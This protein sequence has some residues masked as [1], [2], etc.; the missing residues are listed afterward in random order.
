MADRAGLTPAARRGLSLAALGLA[1]ALALFFGIRFATAPRPP[2]P[3]PLPATAEA[4]APEQPPVA[5]AEAP[6]A[7]AGPAR[8]APPLA[9]PA[10]ETAAPEGS[11][12]DIAGSGS[13]TGA[14]EPDTDQASAGTEVGDIAAPPQDAG[15]EAAPPPVAEAAPDAPL[16]AP[17]SFD[18]VRLE[19]DGMMLV[20]GQAEPQARIGV[21]VDGK[22]ETSALAGADGKFA[23][24]VALSPSPTPRL[25]TL[26]APAPDGTAIASAD[27]VVLGPVV[28]PPPAPPPTQ[29]AEAA[30]DAADAPADAGATLAEGTLAE[31]AADEAGEAVPAP[32]ADAATEP[33][34]APE[35]L[36][37]AATPDAGA[38]EPAEDAP[39]EPVALA[40]ASAALDPPNAPALV[41]DAGGGLDGETGDGLPGDGT[42]VSAADSPVEPPGAAVDGADGAAPED[43][44]PQVILTDASGTAR[45]LQGAGEVPDADDAAPEIAIDAI[46]SGPSGAISVSGRASGGGFARVYADNAEVATV[47]IAEGAWA[48]PLPQGGAGQFT[49]RVDQIDAGGQVVARTETE[50]TRQTRDE[51]EGLL[52]EEVR[53]GGAAGTVVVTVQKGFTLWR[54]A[55]ENYGDGLLYVKVFEANRDQIRNPDLI[56]PGQVFSVPLA[57]EP[58][59]G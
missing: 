10:P 5:A 50:V 17:P 8:E 53:A 1:G 21:L 34:A 41:G 19:A 31:G 9:A 16:P 42:A 59:P 23:A 33:P 6:E 49:L 22:E 54:I 7:P 35:A 2:G 37:A 26:S 30:P 40:D 39:A 18:I 38:T 46:S 45:V 20:A 43:A 44:R 36:A 28:P 51:L 55:R 56:Y 15:Q 12:A 25:L 11:A 32:L 24:M 14:T 13:A 52:V 57:E 3:D 48:A 58:D 27:S 47:Q 29:I 4:P